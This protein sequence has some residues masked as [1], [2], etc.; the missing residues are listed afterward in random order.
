MSFDIQPIRRKVLAH[1]LSM[2]EQD[3]AYAVW[4]A[5]D[6]EKRW[7]EIMYGLNARFTRDLREQKLA[8]EPA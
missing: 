6:Y 4:A 8:K 7:P 3:E 1:C 5:R 2:A